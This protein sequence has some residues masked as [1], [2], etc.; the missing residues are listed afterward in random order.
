MDFIRSTLSRV[1]GISSSSQGPATATTAIASIS[2]AE[3]SESLR[4]TA[5]GLHKLLLNE[6]VII[7][8]YKY[9]SVLDI[10]LFCASQKFMWN[11]ARSDNLWASLIDRDIR[12]IQAGDARSASQWAHMLSILN[13]TDARSVYRTFIPFS[14]RF[15]GLWRMVPSNWRTGYEGGFLNIGI[16]NENIVAWQV[17]A[18]G[19]ADRWLAVDLEATRADCRLILRNV[20]DDPS[21]RVEASERYGRLAL[22]TAKQ[23]IEY[24]PISLKRSFEYSGYIYEKRQLICDRNIVMSGIVS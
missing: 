24:A 4:A 6:D 16:D 22:A 13:F 19:T 2:V 12:P 7:G 9:L 20:Q 21:Q 5:A 8:V 14:T 11:T 18:D 17:D 10:S 1:V 23:T 3:S 15:V